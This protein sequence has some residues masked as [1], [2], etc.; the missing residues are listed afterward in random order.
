M[1]HFLI[2]LGLWNLIGACFMFLLLNKKFGNDFLVKWSQIFKEPYSLNYYGKFWLCWAIG[3][4]LF[5][6]FINCWAVKWDYIHVK[7][8]LIFFNLIIYFIILAILI[9]GLIKSNKLGPGAYIAGVIWAFFIGWG[10]YVL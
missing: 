4:N 7:T 5:Y 10:I 2:G 9:Y 1:N 3:I 8:D 6:G